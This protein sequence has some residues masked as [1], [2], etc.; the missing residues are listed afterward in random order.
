MMVSIYVLPL[1]CLGQDVVA[2]IYE[3]AAGI[4]VPVS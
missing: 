3:A 1:G 2:K 4:L